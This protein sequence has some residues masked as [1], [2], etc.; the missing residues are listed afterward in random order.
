LVKICHGL[1]EVRLGGCLPSKEILRAFRVYPCELQRRLCAGYIT[2]RLSHRCLKERGI[3]LRD[4]LAGF[5][6]RIKIDKQLSDIPRD[7]AAYLHV[8]DGIERA[9]RSHCLC[10]RAARNS[11][12]LI[13]CNPAG[14]ALA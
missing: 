7:L 2:L 12:S 5:D 11:C 9:S 3:N 4:H 6:L 1:I 14:V 10:N 13:I 8:D